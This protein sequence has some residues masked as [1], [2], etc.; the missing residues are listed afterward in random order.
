METVMPACLQDFPSGLSG[1]FG[2][3]DNNIAGHL[4][5]QIAASTLVAVVAAMIIGAVDSMQPQRWW[6]TVVCF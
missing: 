5:E 2:A 6:T 3:A 4:H 1:T